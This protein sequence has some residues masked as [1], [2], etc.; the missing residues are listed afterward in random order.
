MV[1]VKHLL[2]I[3]ALVRFTSFLLVIERSCFFFFSFVWHIRL[4][5]SL[6]TIYFKMNIVP[7]VVRIYKTIFIVKISFIQKGWLCFCFIFSGCWLALFG[8]S[9][10]DAACWLVLLLLF[11]Y[12]KKFKITTTINQPTNPHHIPFKI[13]YYGQTPQKQI[14][15]L[16]Y[17][18]EDSSSGALTIWT[19]HCK[20]SSVVPSAWKKNVF[21][22]RLRHIYFV[23]NFILRLK[24]RLLSPSYRVTVNCSRN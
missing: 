3:T 15:N 5:R 9:A 14:N 13:N 12:I 19:T 22:S 21:W 24:I 20:L 18:R 10:V 8:C 16:L 2:V 7:F 17:R 6:M 23:F 1:D 4:N 11:S